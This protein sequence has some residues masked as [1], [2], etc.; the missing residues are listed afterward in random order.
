MIVSVFSVPVEAQS[1]ENILVIL[2]FLQGLVVTD[3][4]QWDSEASA[5]TAKA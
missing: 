5:V 4:A 3:K 1:R 2:E